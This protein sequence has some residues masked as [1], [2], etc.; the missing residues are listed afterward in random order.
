MQPQS[1]KLLV[2]QLKHEV[3]RKPFQDALNLLIEPFRRLATKRG[4]V[5]VEH[6]PLPPNQADALGDLANRQRRVAHRLG[7]LRGLFRIRHMLRKSKSFPR[8]P[9]PQTI[10]RFAIR[11]EP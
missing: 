10:W 1:R 9:L 2:L 7:P 6:N 11:V 5:G 4:Q 3:R 8:C